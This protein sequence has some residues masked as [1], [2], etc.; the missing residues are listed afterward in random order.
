MP[1]SESDLTSIL[2]YLEEQ[3]AVYEEMQRDLSSRNPAALSL[4]LT[5]ESQA[6]YAKGA[7][8]AYAQAAL[9][10]KALLQRRENQPRKD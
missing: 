6:E 4:R 1:V 3:S 9:R 10:I 5:F 2:L 7:S 8:T